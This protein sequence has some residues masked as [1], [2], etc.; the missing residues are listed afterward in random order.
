MFGTEAG[1]PV[2]TF[3]RMWRELFKLAGLDYGRV[4]RP[5]VAHDPP[6]I[7]FTAISRT[8]AIRS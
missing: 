4:K 5:D 1:K 6:R 3:K 8:Q 7:R 2:K